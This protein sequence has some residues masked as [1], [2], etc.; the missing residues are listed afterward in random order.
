MLPYFNMADAV[1]LN[2]VITPHAAVLPL[3]I[4]RRSTSATTTI[5]DIAGEP[6]MDVS[7]L[8]QLLTITYDSTPSTPTFD[9]PPEPYSVS[10]STTFPIRRVIVGALVPVAFVVMFASAAAYVLIKMFLVGV[11]L[12]GI[13][14]LLF[15]PLKFW[16]INKTVVATGEP[17]ALEEAGT[18]VSDVDES[19]AEAAKIDSKSADDVV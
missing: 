2:N 17:H 8:R 6:P 1:L 13:W 12:V 10:P 19:N 7:H 14:V 18:K 4:T 5:Y 16:N 9:F 3:R 11:M 15:G